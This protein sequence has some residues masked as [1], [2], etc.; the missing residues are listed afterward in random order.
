MVAIGSLR[1]VLAMSMDRTQ[2]L[3]IF[4]L[5]VVTPSEPLISGA[6]SDRHRP[7]LAASQSWPQWRVFYFIP[8]FA[9]AAIVIVTVYQLIDLPEALRPL[10]EY[11]KPP[12]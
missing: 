11:W 2:L 4:V 8:K 6:P 1:H 12:H 3:M 9:L 10:M 5:L 7:T